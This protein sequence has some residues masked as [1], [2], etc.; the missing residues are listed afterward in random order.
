MRNILSIVGL[1]TAVMGCSQGS[2]PVTVLGPGP[3]DPAGSAGDP[4]GPTQD[5]LDPSGSTGSG[6]GAG[7]STGSGSLTTTG[8]GASTS[9]SSTTGS[10]SS[11]GGTVTFSCNISASFICEEFDA[12]PSA[13]LSTEQSACSSDGGTA[14][15]GCPTSNLLGSCEITSGGFDTKEFYY[16]GGALTAASAQTSC[17]SS[18]GT[19]TAG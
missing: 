7:G 15:T 19:W 5:N 14:G 11:G 16:S 3:S 10:S 2:T 18:N 6:N 13:D 4:S 9:T 12:L 8:T 17:Q 1:V